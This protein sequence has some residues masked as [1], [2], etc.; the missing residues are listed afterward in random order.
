MSLSRLSL[1]IV[2]LQQ[3]WAPQMVDPS[4]VA[5]AFLRATERPEAKGQRYILVSINSSYTPLSL[6]CIS[7]EAIGTWLMLP[8]SFASG[9]P[10][11]GL[12]DNI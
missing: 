9:Q 4:D 2:T 5:L 1:H 3:A 10:V 11:R 8:E 6:H 7:P 12:L